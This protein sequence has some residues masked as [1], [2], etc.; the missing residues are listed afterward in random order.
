M[1]QI[2]KITQL[3]QETWVLCYFGKHWACQDMDDQTQLI[4]DNLTKAS[5][6]I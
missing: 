6:D 1:K 5:I 4:L 3:F 2:N